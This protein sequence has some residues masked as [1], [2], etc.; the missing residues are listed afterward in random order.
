MTS[1][2]LM[3]GRSQLVRLPAGVTPV[4]SAAHESAR[5]LAYR[6]T[7]GPA[8]LLYAQD[9]RGL[10][11]ITRSVTI[12]R[13][14]LA[15][16]PEAVA[17][18]TTRSRYAHEYPLPERCEYIKLPTRL[19]PRTIAQAPEEEERSKEHFRN[20]R[21]QILRA[22]ALGLT[23]DLVLVDHEPL[24]ASGEFRDGLWALKAE[25]PHTKFVFGL[26]DIMDDPDRIRAEWRDSGVY[27]ALEGLY[28][29]I[30]VYG[31]PDLYDVVAV[32][33]I[34]P[35]VQ[36]KLHYCGYVVRDPPA[37][38]DRVAV[39]ERYGLPARGPLV[40]A[41]VGSGYD[42]YPVLD[43]AMTALDRLQ[44]KFRM[45]SAIVVTGPFMSPEKKAALAALATPTCRVVERADNYQLMAAAD[46]M[47]SMGGYNSVCEALATA[48]PLVIVPRSTHK[49]EQ[50]IRA[51]MLAEHGV[52][53]WIHPKEL[54]GEC[55]AEAL[56]WALRR[57]RRAHAELVRSVIP[58]FDGARRLTA[59]LSRWL[60]G[61]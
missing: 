19:A 41:A 11:H 7:T 1:T 8:V 33:D 53:R 10:G 61:D 49:I 50:Q 34:P 57:D 24:G 6:W 14:M 13:H 28:D 20:L 16:Y 48:C 29:G 47:V 40:L 35:S 46:A 42:G 51:R 54:H 18:I 9:V 38:I 43:A 4:P 32:Y 52:A 5:V 36:P 59:Y 44:R 31:S 45:L 39:R 15:A 3:P 26:R 21:R 58:S 2:P 27:D 37:S 56:E 30:A 12:A 60:G 25:S 22:V 17:Y 55:L 23:P